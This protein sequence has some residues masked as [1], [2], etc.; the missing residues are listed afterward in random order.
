VAQRKLAPA[1]AEC[2]IVAYQHSS[3]LG[4]D[5][6]PKASVRTDPVG[7]ARR[8]NQGRG[9][10]DRALFAYVNA[11]TPTPADPDRPAL[12][13]PGGVMLPIEDMRPGWL[14][15]S[16]CTTRKRVQPADG[17]DTPP[18]VGAPAPVT[19]AMASGAVVTFMGT[20]MQFAVSLFALV[21]RQRCGERSVLPA[22]GDVTG[23]EAGSICLG[24]P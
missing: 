3:A 21:S 16:R 7:R 15:R 6:Q 13:S 22:A 10:A 18:K 19:I 9:A 8:R 11:R 12:V 17:A 14:L 23:L 20:T 2:W 1:A 5:R 24:W 4:A